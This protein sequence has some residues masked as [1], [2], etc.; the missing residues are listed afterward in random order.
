MGPP[1]KEEQ[2][3]ALSQPLQPFYQPLA[4]FNLT[5]QPFLSASGDFYHLTSLW[6]VV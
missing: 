2:E 4:I 1:S 3:E 6:R 5:L